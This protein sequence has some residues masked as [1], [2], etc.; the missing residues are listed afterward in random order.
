[1]N[2]PFAA[3]LDEIIRYCES[4]PPTPMTAQGRIAA[5]AVMNLLYE[6]IQL[7]RD[8]PSSPLPMVESLAL[9]ALATIKNW[10]EIR[11][12]ESDKI[13]FEDDRQ[14]AMEDMHH[15]LFQQLWT[16]FDIDAYKAERITRYETRIDIN[17]LQPLIA[18]KRVID[19]GCGHGNFAHALVNRGAAF[20]LGIDF[21]E[22]SVAYATEIRD[23]LGVPAER[24]SFKQATVYE[25]GEA[26]ES[27][28]FAI[29]NGVFHHTDDEDR[30]YREVHRVLKT[31]GWFWVYTD[32]E[33]AISHRLWDA[34]RQALRNIPPEFIVRQLA[35]LNLSAGKRY[36]LGD[37]MNAVYRHTNWEEL[38]SR[39]ERLGFTNFK[40]MVGGFATDFDHD[41]IAADKFGAEKFGSGDLR[42]IC[43]KAASSG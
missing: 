25:S 14:A 12:A 15:D 9:Q 24:I 30:A 23:R 5:L 21:G 1:M 18:G 11:Y 4:H 10:D 13:S 37:G 20:V 31:G 42:L 22:K 33:N 39:L 40:R 28:D 19:F 7:D 3:V 34:T 36:H 16:Q 29:Q 43:Q 17:H 8:L 26:E 35:L 2:P 6:K 27:F 32:G 41:V 38:T